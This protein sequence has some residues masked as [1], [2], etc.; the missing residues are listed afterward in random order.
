MREMWKNKFKV[1]SSKF[2]VLSLI[3]PEFMSKEQK[4]TR[5]S[6][7]LFTFY[8]SL[9]TLLT[10]CQSK[11][12]QKEL[13]ADIK[14][15]CSMHPQI[16]ENEPGSC[17]ICGMDLVPMHQ[18][19]VKTGVDADLADLIQPANEAVISKVKT[20]TVRKS[21]L[22]DTIL[23]NGMVNY[24]TNHLKTISSRVSGR[25]E[26]LFVKYNFE[27][28]Y[29]GQKIMEIYSPDLAAAQQEL[30]YLETNGDAALLEHAKTK[31][32]LL[33]VA[34]KQIN[35]VLASGKVNYSIPVYS[36]FSGY[37]IDTKVASMN[38]N[39]GENIESPPVLNTDNNVISIIEGSYVKTGDV[40]F[41]LFNDAE[42]WAEVYLDANQLTLIHKDDAV[43]ISG[44]D[45]EQHAKINLIQ[46][47]YSNGQHYGVL[48]IHLANAQKSFKIGEL[49]KAEIPLPE[50]QGL[51][52]PASSV[53]HLGNK[54]IA[55]IKENKVLKPKEMVISQKSSD[56][57]LIKSGLNEGDEIAENA[58]Y[59]IDTQSFIKVKDEYEN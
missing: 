49:L 59:L 43:K 33:G 21:S 55:F 35:Q 1:D 37:L 40:L 52:I 12:S 34:E 29:R 25:I 58:G 36:D 39:P 48:R 47:Y 5:E 23:A 2:K 42:V 27:K 51:W 45:Q 24:N 38:L 53:Y 54:S 31:L 46:P 6:K 17:P 30:L 20:I 11:T 18:H 9:F 41:K 26:Q 28:V 16:V 10:A 13:D 7:V 22:K 15:T 3:T 14:Y 19:E 44:G 50:K 32:R 56:A 4:L 57:Y 8:F